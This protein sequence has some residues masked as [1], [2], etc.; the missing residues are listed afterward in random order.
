MRIIAREGLIARC[1]AKSVEREVNLI[2]LQQEDLKPEDY[3]VVHAGYAIQKI[4]PREARE[5]WEI[6]DQIL[7]DQPGFFSPD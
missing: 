6:Y 5:T 2:M 3:V 7:A 4:T 1:E